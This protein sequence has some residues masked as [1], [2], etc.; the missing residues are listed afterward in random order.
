MVYPMRKVI[1]RAN[2]R[3][4]KFTPRNGALSRPTP[5]DPSGSQ[6]GTPNEES[7][8]KN[9]RNALLALALTVGTAACGSN[10]TGPE[11]GEYI[12]GPGSYIPGPGSY[13]PGPGS[14]I[15][16]PGSY[17]PG[18]GSYIPGPG[19]YIPGPGS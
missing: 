17:I 14:Y 9:L 16:G 13:I 12:P 5:L 7:I 3:S 4:G 6:D 10:L 1:L 8:M 15:P 2:D 11:T 18:P 19:S